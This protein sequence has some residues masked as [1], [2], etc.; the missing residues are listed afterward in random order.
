MSRN[1]KLIFVA[2]LLCLTATARAHFTV[3]TS[4]SARIARPTLQPAAARSAI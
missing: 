4:S 2:L 1:R 3:R